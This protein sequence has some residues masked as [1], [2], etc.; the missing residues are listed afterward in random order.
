MPEPLI[1]GATLC[2]AGVLHVRQGLD[3]YLAGSLR[4]P[5]GACNG[6]RALAL[7]RRNGPGQQA[8]ALAGRR[9]RG[10]LR[11]RLLLRGVALLGAL[12]AARAAGSTR[13]PD[14]CCGPRTCPLQ[15]ATPQSAGSAQVVS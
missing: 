4:R 14:R 13:L 11:M 9:G 5:S 7:G 2:L 10:R 6:R 3:A 8:G 15:L 1:S 12:G